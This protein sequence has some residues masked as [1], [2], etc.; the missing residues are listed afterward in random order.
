G[1]QR[2][3]RALRTREHLEREARPLR[4]AHEYDGRVGGAL[5]ERV[6]QLQPFVQAGLELRPEH[7]TRLDVA[8][9]VPAAVRCLRGDDRQTWIVARELQAAAHHRVRVATASV[10]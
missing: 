6:Q 9:A 7:L 3:E 4:K 10:E 1:D 2:R 8:W 5:R